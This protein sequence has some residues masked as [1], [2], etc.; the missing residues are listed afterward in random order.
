M[1]PSSSERV[2]VALGL[3]WALTWA[4]TW[5]LAGCPAETP[6]EDAGALLGVD[7]P[8]LDAPGLDAARLL[9]PDAPFPDVPLPDAPG[10]DAPFPDAALPDSGIAP[11]PD[12]RAS[13]EAD[14]GVSGGCPGYATRYWD[15]CKAHCGWSANAAP[16]APL[17]SCGLDDAPLTSAEAPSSCGSSDASAAYTCFDM[18]PWAVTDTLAYGFAAVPS[19]GAICGR[20]YRLEFDGTG[21]YDARDPGSVALAGKVMVV[22]AT[23]I[24]HDV[25]GG[26]FDLLIPGGGV[27]LFNACSRQWGVSDAELGAQY[28]GLLTACRAAGGTHDA[29]RACVR[30]RCA[31]IFDGPE[32]ADLRAGCDWFLDWYQAADNPNLRYQEVPCPDALV[33]RSGMDRRPLADVA[34]PSCGS[35]GSCECDCSWA[36]GGCGA[37]DGSCCWRTCCGS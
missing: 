1:C 28:G 2:R 29:V 10:L 18:A 35:S 6:S 7:A 11:E 32:H 19:S 23:N 3:T 5:M 4:L 27:G 33:M 9:A 37:D 13:V 12:A 30:S 25:A 16:L 34:A 26:Q 17:Q 31:S 20:C 15:C 22:Q 14:A 21:H 36:A 24:G 8:E